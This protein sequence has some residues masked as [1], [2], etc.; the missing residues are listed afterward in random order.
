MLL[1]H[2][3]NIAIEVPRL[4]PSQRLLDFGA[5]FYL[6][7]DGEQA[8]KWA[9]RTTLIRKDGVPTVSV[10]EFPETA[11][12]EMEV[13]SFKR[14]GKQWLDFVCA[15]RRG[16][17]MKRKY[18]IVTGPVAD[19]RTVRALNNYMGGFLSLELTLQILRPY[20]LKDQYA[21]K[22]ERALAFLKFKE[23]LI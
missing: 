15:N 19:D 16:Q 22:T 18:D 21:F 14:P 2:G 1:Y 3:S 7:S 4:I 13:L 6:T 20:H 10:F 8:G 5:G 17:P 23:V 12:E 11:F 9:L